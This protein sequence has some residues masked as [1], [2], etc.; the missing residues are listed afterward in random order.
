MTPTGCPMSAKAEQFDAFGDEFRLDP[1]EALR[2]ARAQEPVFYNPKL[3]YWVVSRY[4][5]V[6]A[7]FRD[8]ILFSP[9][10]VLEKITPSPPE[11]MEILKRY[12][13]ALNRT[14][15]NEDEP[16]HME[17]RRLLM[18]DF[19]PERLEHHAPM[20]RALTR[21]AMDQFIEKGQAELVA[22]MF[23]EIPQTVALKF[24][25]VDEE[26]IEDLKSFSVAHTTNTW[27][28]PEPEEQLAVAEAVGEFWQASGRILEKMK[29]NPDAPGWM[30]TS[31]RQHLKYPEIV[32]ESYLHSMMMAI[33]VAAHE[34]TANASANAFRMLLSQ[35]GVWDEIVENP[36]LIPN[37]VEE[38][39]RHSGPIAAWRRQA[40]QDTE[41]GGVAIPE[42][43]KLLIATASANH[44]KRQFENPDLL[45]L[46]RDNSADHLTFGY[47]SHQCMG[48]NIGRMEMRI[49]LDEFT[50]R[51]PHIKLKQDQSFE[52]PANISFRGPKAVWVEWDPALNPDVIRPPMDFPIGPPEKQ[53]IIRQ[54]TVAGAE[55]RGEVMYLTLQDPRGRDL[56]A[57]SAGAHVDLIVGAYVRKYS[58]CGDA[59]DRKH[60]Q[61]AILRE[62]DGRGGSKHIHDALQTG[63]K[64]S[65][66]GPH[67]HFHLGEAEDTHVLIAGGIGITP[68]L[69]MAD[70]LKAMGSPYE[71]HFAGR[72]RNAMPLLLRAERDHGEC[73]MVYAGDESRRLDL[74]QI[75]KDCS[76]ARPVYA[77]GPE[78][79]LNALEDLAQGWPEHSLHFE[80]FSA[81]ENLLDPENEH[82]FEV[83]LRDSG[84]TLS[85]RPDQTLHQ[86]LQ[87]AG[88]DIACDCKEGLCGSCEAIVTEGEIDHR[89]RV[90][91]KAE[92]AEGTRMMTCCSRAKGAKIAL[93]L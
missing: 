42:G 61:L 75:T 56:P 5:D 74:A 83:D 91:S 65:V 77:C 48:K 79:L 93:A 71:L 39:L 64:V 17:R 21:E 18:E 15:V 32:T 10:I 54:L 40:T 67:N 22:D 82:G 9:S 27:G 70:R 76:A 2:W 16:A 52:F 73:L 49:F 63:S 81:A 84:L 8:N 90:L 4:A 33:L 69:A 7:V 45:D 60:W 66:T 43:A 85:V 34:T 19:L 30:Q 50:R 38:C 72:T 51:L 41:I 92:R 23:W 62:E 14:L 29:A 20:V 25:G 47:G 6:K 36:G 46:Y 37:A 59:T 58:L 26:D 44:D 80:H 88:I 68:I 78:R 53:S 12:D 1:A 55:T 24:L 28:R 87:G 89:D 86:A 11:A 13:Y 35:P 3:G 57:W 31:I